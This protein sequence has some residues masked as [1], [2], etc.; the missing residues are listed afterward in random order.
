MLQPSQLPT[1]L[2]FLGFILLLIAIFIV[3]F[4]WGMRKT[5]TALQKLAE[6]TDREVVA[7]RRQMLALLVGIPLFLLSFVLSPLVWHQP[8]PYT[9]FVGLITG[10]VPL[11]YIA[12]SS[13]RNR[14]SIL[15]GRERLP[16]KGTKAIWSG[17]LNL[18]LIFV[19][20]TGYTL[21]FASGK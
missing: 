10:F 18:V 2:L 9:V 11:A 5:I 16:V 17:V 14:V 6:F 4:L 12:V 15:R 13:I 19:V 20:V 8:S 21:Y 3:I 1:Y 7:V